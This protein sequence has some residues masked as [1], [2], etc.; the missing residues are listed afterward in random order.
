MAQKHDSHASPHPTASPA[1]VLPLRTSLS[2]KLLSSVIS[3]PP[4][5]R[6]AYVTFLLAA[7]GPPYDLLEFGRRQLVSRND[8]LPLL[9]SILP[10]VHIDGASS[11]LHAFMFTSVDRSDACLSTLRAISLDG[12]IG[13]CF[14]D[15]LQLAAV[16]PGICSLLCP[17][18][19]NTSS[20]GYFTLQPPRS[21][22]LFIRMRNAAM[23][24]FMLWQKSLFDQ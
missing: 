24:L 14:P 23:P 18:T 15:P 13:K 11:L 6:I 3:L 4:N 8:S 10:H 21:I 5:S 22:S 16:P 17:V 9:E 19:H 7:D 1:R 12:L 2:D 20:F